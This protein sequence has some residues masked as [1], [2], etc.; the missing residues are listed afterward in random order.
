MEQMA[1]KMFFTILYAMHHLLL[2]MVKKLEWLLPR[3][4]GVHKP[5]MKM[6][7]LLTVIT[8]FKLL[9]DSPFLSK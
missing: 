8:R 1:V 5:W 7:I 2:Q 3:M 6:S 9:L 4:Q